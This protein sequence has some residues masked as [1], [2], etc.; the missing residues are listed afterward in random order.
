MEACETLALLHHLFFN[1]LV[2][3]Y[4]SLILTYC[5][6]LLVQLLFCKNYSSGSD[7]DML[8]V[9]LSITILVWVSAWVCM[10]QTADRQGLPQHARIWS[11]KKEKSSEGKCLTDS[12][13]RLVGDHQKVAGTQI[14]TGYSQWLQNSITPLLY[15]YKYVSLQLN[16]KE[17]SFL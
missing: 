11:H 8:K 5:M 2:V 1:D 4:T 15:K 10:L 6:H 7:V 17:L 3:T 16:R 9:K 12:K 14:I 13:T